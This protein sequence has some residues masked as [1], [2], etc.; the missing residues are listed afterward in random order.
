M[1]F[2]ITSISYPFLLIFSNPDYYSA[3]LLVLP[4]CLA[5]SFES[6][7]W[8]TELGI[9]I[10]KKPK[11]YLISYGIFLLVSVCSIFYFQKCLV[12]SV[13]VFQYLLDN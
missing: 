3:S 5:L 11:Y 2:L 4:L 10:A 7:G 6:I 8:I 9:N 1:S 13:F 12:F